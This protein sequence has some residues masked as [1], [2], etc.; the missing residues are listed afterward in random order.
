LDYHSVLEAKMLFTFLNILNPA[1]TGIMLFLAVL[2]FVLSFFIAGCE[3]AFFSLT[4]KDINLLKTKQQPSFR[5]I[6]RLLEE[7]KTLQATMLIANVFV[8]IGAILVCNFLLNQLLEKQNFSPAWLMLLKIG[9]ITLLIVLFAE[10]L[11]KVWAAHHKVWFASS[12]SLI[13]EIFNSIFYR[14]S[15][16]IVNFT[17][18][19]EKRIGDKADSMH[20]N[21]LD[22]VIDLLPEHEAS[23]EE[24]QILKGIRKFGDTE[25]KQIMRTRM[26]VNGIEY[27]CN[28]KDVISKIEALHY[29]RLPVYKNNLDEIVG[30]LHTKDLLLHLNE[31]NQFEWQPLIR[32]AYFV[33]EQKLIEDLMQDFRTKRIH[34]AV[35]VDEFGGTSGIVTL[36]DIM[37]EIIGD[38]RDEF[39][40][41]ESINK[42]LDDFN[43]IFEG[44]FSINDA[45]KAM[46]LPIDTFDSVRGDSDSVAGLVLEIAGEFPQINTV[47]VSGDFSFVP[48]EIN[49][50]RIDKVKIIIQQKA[51]SNA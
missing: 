15:R 24:K 42:K 51:D 33:H 7:P 17:D 40:D 18:K 13:L 49:K 37:E 45:C 16:R 11:P 23:N 3:V 26:D 41:E 50:N 19:I 39:D 31:N 1:T 36:E 10:V 44:R 28:F 8:N 34:F 29:S 12:S 47:L 21:N 14:V 25:V 5:R 43:Y 6:V 27:N 46:G 20:D 32:P 35:V 30:M 4:T 2:L 22:Y 48:L 9:I 38:I